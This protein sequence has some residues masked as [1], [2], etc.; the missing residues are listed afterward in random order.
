MGWRSLYLFGLAPLV[1]VAFAR[2]SIQESTRFKKDETSHEFS[3]GSLLRGPYR[4]RL[5]L[6]GAIWSLSY[7]GFSNAVTFW[8]DFVMEHRGWDD[9]QVGVA[10]TIAAVASMPLIF[11]S[12]ALLDKIGR[13]WGAVIIYTLGC[14]GVSGAFLFHDPMAL[15]IA[16][17]FAI[18]GVSGFLPV[19]N[20]YGTE[21]FPTKIR[22][23]AYAW[24][25][26]ILGRIG[27]VLAPIIIA[28]MANLSLFGEKLEMGGAM[29]LA[30]LAPIL[31]LCIM[32]FSF[33][34]TKN[35]DLEQTSAL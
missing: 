29:A 16:L 5:L 18:F 27:Y 15:Q 33:P 2:R 20:S 6:I 25:N 34:E 21:L 22:S 14:A 28:Y 11:S 30:T 12:G 17:V 1:L 19:L 4:N 35:Q 9:G 13:K 7:L 31:A 10:L 23:E 32:L 8:K 3:L 26:N 24:G